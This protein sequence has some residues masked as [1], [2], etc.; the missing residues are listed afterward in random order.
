MLAQYY[1]RLLESDRA[2]V[3]QQGF[4]FAN[5]RE[6]DGLMGMSCFS[7]DLRELR[8]FGSYVRN[9]IST[10]RDTVS[11]QQLTW[12]KKG[13]EPHISLLIFLPQTVLSWK[14]IFL[15]KLI[16]EGLCWRNRK[17]SGATEKPI[18]R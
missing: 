8:R 13:K 5:K 3:V 4:K 11:M 18:V 9:R 16:L 7:P 10:L 12:R 1:S 15:M 14:N 17:I 2:Q 6:E